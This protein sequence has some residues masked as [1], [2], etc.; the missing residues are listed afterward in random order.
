MI[1]ADSPGCRAR[2]SGASNGGGDLG[3]GDH[4]VRGDGQRVG[5]VR[6]HVPARS[7]RGARAP[8]RGLGPRAVEALEQDNAEQDARDQTRAR[9]LGQLLH[10]QPDR[11]AAR[12]RAHPARHHT[13]AGQRR[14]QTDS[15]ARRYAPFL[16]LPGR[17]TTLCN[18][19]YSLTKCISCE[20]KYRIKLKCSKQRRQVLF[21]SKY[22]KIVNI[23]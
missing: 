4:S 10:L 17:V 12:A 2:E 16:L 21:D 11:A 22:R 19:I 15:P 1:C 23:Y 6:A 14:G 9:A 20:Y 7:L 3:G 5:R 13:R 18:V 8:S